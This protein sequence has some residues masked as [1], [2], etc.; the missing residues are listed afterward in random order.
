M[1]EKKN[2]ISISHVFA[3]YSSGKKENDYVLKDISLDIRE[4][5]SVS[6]IGS[7]GSGKTTLLRV[8]AGLLHHRGEVLF[9]QKNIDTM[10][11]KQIAARIAML[12]QVSHVYFSYNV[13][14]TI[15][16]GRYVHNSFWGDYS[17]DNKEIVD[18]TIETFG[19]S[20]IVDKKIT[21]LSGGQL[22]KV[23]LARCIA[24]RSPVILLDEPMNHLD[25]KVQAEFMHYLNEWKRNGVAW[26]DGK[27]YMP[28]I[29]G[30]FHDIN[31]AA[32]MADDVV[33]LKDGKI[34][35]SGEKKEVI[36][37]ETLCD[38]FDFDIVSFLRDVWAM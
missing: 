16:Q 23:M 38:V 21:S 4:G 13:Y 24:Q 6:I 28:T 5:S 1:P 3:G 33:C 8:I 12:S 31:I 25:L 30:V 27:K 32:R 2:I 10:T 36:T 9:D 11:R 19:L 22:Q 14:D 20:Q 18:E 15:M 35:L 7:N 26:A 37:S 29:I 17:R 34:L